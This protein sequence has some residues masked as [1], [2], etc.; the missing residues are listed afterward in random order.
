MY[1]FIVFQQVTSK[2]ESKKKSTT[3]DEEFNDVLNNIIGVDYLRQ[4]LNNDDFS[5]INSL[6]LLV[7]TNVQSFDNLGEILPV[8]QVLILDNSVI[9]SIRDLG[10]SLSH[11]TTLSLNNCGI[12]ELD[13]ISS[14]INLKYLSLRDNQISDVCGL[15]MLENLQVCIYIFVNKC[16]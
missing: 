1:F 12:T 16:I 3:I 2:H 11:I 13:G 9:V 8:I 10:T 5:N 14:F 4:L 7:N 6:E 15:A